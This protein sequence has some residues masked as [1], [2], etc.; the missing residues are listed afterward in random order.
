MATLEAP[1]SLHESGAD[2]PFSIQELT[3]AIYQQ[4]QKLEE[5][6]K[7][8]SKNTDQLLDLYTL[9][10]ETARR[11]N[12]DS[13]VSQTKKDLDESLILTEI[14]HARIAMSPEHSK[15]LL[16]AKEQARWH[17]ST[18][19]FIHDVLQTKSPENAFKLIS[20]YWGEQRAIYTHPF[21]QFPQDVLRDNFEKHK[22][23]VLAAVAFEIALENM[24]GW[25]LDVSNL[26]LDTAY[27][28][29]YVL[30]SPEGTTYLIQLTSTKAAGSEVVNVGRLRNT[31]GIKGGPRDKRDKFALGVSRYM[32]ERHMSKDSVTA[33]YIEMGHDA[34][35]AITGAPTPK[36]LQEISS[37]FAEIEA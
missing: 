34:F 29:D 33:L 16:S 28:I 26:R 5:N 9:L 23:G 31:D 32:Q 30:H 18:T 37:S 10:K 19:A 8:E 15:H 1:Q 11:N 21:R 13:S 20:A 24:I 3:Q 36:A 7:P 4:E 25:K 14:A 35:D 6:S 17:Q 22:S 12:A 2:K 27:A